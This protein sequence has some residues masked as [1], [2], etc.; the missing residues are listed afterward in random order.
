MVL[1]GLSTWV[2]WSERQGSDVEEDGVPEAPLLP[3]CDPAD[4]TALRIGP[5][6]KGVSLERAADRWLLAGDPPRPAEGAL[7]DLAARSLCELDSLRSLDGTG[8]LSQFGLGTDS[9]TVSA[10]VAGTTRSLRLGDSAPVGEGRYAAIDGALHLVS[11]AAVAVFDRDPLDFRDR[12]VLPLDPAEVTAL[13]LQR[14]E[15][16][17]AFERRQRWWFLA[18]EPGWRAETAALDGLLQDLVGL[19]AAA[20]PDSVL[21]PVASVSLDLGEQS[22]SISFAPSG[23]AMAAVASGEALPAGFGGE[24]AQVD[25]SFLAALPFEPEAWRALELVDFN[26]YVVDE[27]RWAAAGESFTFVRTDGAWARG[28][29]GAKAD[30][31]A[32]QDFLTALDGLR[33]VGFVDAAEGAVEVARVEAAERTGRAFEL[34]LLRSPTRDLVRIESETGLREVDGAAFELLGHLDTLAQGGAAL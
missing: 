10:T 8:D 20:Y 26:P 31:G 6:G 14:G 3:D 25:A 13:T 15:D 28:E 22:A 19:S 32:V 29:E 5:E 34:V 9:R 17:L 2:W 16:I 4:V 21:D 7:A 23:V 27:F 33:A 24:G 30:A 12:R 1:A 11:P 18:E